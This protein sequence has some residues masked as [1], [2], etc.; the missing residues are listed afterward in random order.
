MG[1]ED[2]TAYYTG[3]ALF[4]SLYLSVMTPIAS[5]FRSDSSPAHY[6]GCNLK[7]FKVCCS[8]TVIRLSDDL[9]IPREHQGWPG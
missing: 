2:N 4:L 7:V 8:T 5:L 1:I 3:C 6:V 9:G